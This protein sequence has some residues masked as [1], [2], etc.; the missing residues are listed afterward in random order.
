MF[1][2]HMSGKSDCIFAGPE[3]FSSWWQL[4]LRYLSQPVS[5]QGETDINAVPQMLFTT[6]LDLFTRCDILATTQMLVVN[7]IITDI[8]YLNYD[9]S[10]FL[11]LSRGMSF[12]SIVQNLGTSGYID[13]A[14]RTIV[15]VAL[16]LFTSAVSLLDDLVAVF[17][18]YSAI[19]EHF[20]LF[21][22]GIILGK[23]IRTILSLYLNGI[24]FYSNWFDFF[25][26]LIEQL[27][28]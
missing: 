17:M 25:L 19:S 26:T 3:I 14:W 6:A 18:L 11:K 12:M 8:V 20:D 7:K 22:V 4:L 9:P 27:F 23:A 15:W 21:N 2:V 28:N 16:V 5:F 10:S 1:K 24:L 13:G